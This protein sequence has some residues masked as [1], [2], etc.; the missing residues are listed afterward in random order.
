MI[1][2]GLNKIPRG[3]RDPYLPPYG[4]NPPEGCKV[5][6]EDLQRWAIFTIFQ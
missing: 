4:T 1:Q 6:G 5:W 3:A 2:E